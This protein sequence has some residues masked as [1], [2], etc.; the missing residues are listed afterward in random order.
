[1]STDDD[2]KRSIWG[3][4]LAIALGQSKAFKKYHEGHFMQVLH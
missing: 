3:Y 1:M 2:V 4:K